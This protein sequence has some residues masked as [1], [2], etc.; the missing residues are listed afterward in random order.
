MVGGQA[1]RCWARK[2]RN[3]N[4]HEFGVKCNIMNERAS[5]SKLSFF[6]S[7]WISRYVSHYVVFAVVNVN[8]L[9]HV[10]GVGTGGL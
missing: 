1:G 7:K 2:E 3:R 6:I 4:P 8:V 10:P 9:D 5:D